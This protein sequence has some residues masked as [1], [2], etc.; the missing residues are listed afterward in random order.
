LMLKRLDKTPAL[1]V[2][3]VK[4]RRVCRCRIQICG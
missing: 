2:L 3:L 4:D 1:G